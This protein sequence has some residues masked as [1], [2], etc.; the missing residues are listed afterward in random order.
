MIALD[1]LISQAMPERTRVLWQGVFWGGTDQSI[2]G[3]GN[4]T[5]ARPKGEDVNWF[6]VG[7]AK[8][9]N[10]YSVYVNA[11]ADGVYLGQHYADRLGNAKIGAASIGF[12]RLENIDLEVL[13]ELVSRANEVAPPDPQA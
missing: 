8:Q 11:V 12:R 6:L 5:Q 1:Q 2:I 7:L 13:A 10:N 3:Y 9:K 4:I